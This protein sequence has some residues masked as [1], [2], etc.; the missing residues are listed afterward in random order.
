MNNATGFGYDVEVLEWV[1]GED[2]GFH[3]DHVEGKDVEVS[4]LVENNN[5]GTGARHNMTITMIYHRKMTI[6]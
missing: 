1:E 6:R 2:S 5:N 4:P 3:N